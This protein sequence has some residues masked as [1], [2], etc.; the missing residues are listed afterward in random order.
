LRAEYLVGGLPT[1]RRKSV[2]V[3]R[4]EAS[5]REKDAVLVVLLNLDAAAVNEPTLTFEESEKKRCL[6]EGLPWPHSIYES[7]CGIPVGFNG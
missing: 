6:A 4:L 1:C 5:D 3:E 7:T 2:A